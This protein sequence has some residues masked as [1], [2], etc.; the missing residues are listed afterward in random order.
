MMTLV[1][2]GKTTGLLLHMLSSIFHLGCYVVLDSR[3]CM[4]KALI[5]LKKKGVFAAALM[6]QQRYWVALVPGDHIIDYFKNKAVGS[7]DAISGI[8]YGIKH[9]LWCMKEPEYCMLIMA[10][11]GALCAT[12]GKEVKRFW[13]LVVNDIIMASSCHNKMGLSWNSQKAWHQ[14]TFFIFCPHMWGI[15]E[16]KVLAFFIFYWIFELFGTRGVHCAKKKKALLEGIVFAQQFV[17]CCY[18]PKVTKK[19]CEICLFWDVMYF[20]KSSQQTALPT[21][22]WKENRTS[23]TTTFKCAKTFEYHFHYRH[24]VDD[25]NNLQHAVPSLEGTWQADWWPI[26]VFSILLAITK[27]N[28]Y[29]VI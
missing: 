18:F 28:T 17:L 25:H 14:T 1:L 5:E 15:P 20:F 13:N 26:H 22:F 24:A 19:C 16:K 8:L 6:K 10:T 2:S 11:G 9:N 7:I 23:K 29:L 12:E 3:F 4:I 27:I 21:K